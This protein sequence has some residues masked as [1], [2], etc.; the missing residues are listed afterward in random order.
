MRLMRLMRSLFGH[1][2]SLNYVVNV[3]VRRLGLL[4]RR[5]L[6]QSR[7]ISQQ[8]LEGRLGKHQLFT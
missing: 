6:L 5:H 4:A 7:R 2:R 1:Q 3:H 8:T